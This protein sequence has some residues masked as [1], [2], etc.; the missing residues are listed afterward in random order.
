MSIMLIFYT[1]IIFRLDNLFFLKRQKN[2]NIKY[3]YKY[4]LK[5]QC[6]KL[7]KK[8][9]TIKNVLINPQAL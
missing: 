2:L 6:F 9:R 7:I 4:L 3:K 5:Y 1:F 8:Y